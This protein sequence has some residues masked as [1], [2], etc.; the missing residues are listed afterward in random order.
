MELRCYLCDKLV[1]HD[2]FRLE[3]NIVC[4]EC[5]DKRWFS[6]KINFVNKKW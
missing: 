6:D 1:K 4:E 3:C 2:N 5:F